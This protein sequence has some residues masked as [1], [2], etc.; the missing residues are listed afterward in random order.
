MAKTLVAATAMAIYVH[1]T[2]GDALVGDAAD[3]RAGSGEATVIL[4]ES[5]QA[6]H[7]PLLSSTE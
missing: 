7:T 3:V 4:C 6:N 5:T 2:N 1:V